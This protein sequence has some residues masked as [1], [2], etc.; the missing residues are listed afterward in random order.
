VN[1]ILEPF[2]QM[3]TKEEKQYAY[4]QQD[5]ATAHTSQHSMETHREVFGERIISQ[6]LELP[7]SPDL[8]VCDFYM[9]DNLK[10]K[11]CRNNL[12]TPETPPE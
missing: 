5:N 1:N 7:H 12:S 10:Q 2:F 8:S 6:R 11:A 3:L 4:I 9:W